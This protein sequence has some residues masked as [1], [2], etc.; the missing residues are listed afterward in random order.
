MSL[1]LRMTLLSGLAVFAAVVL[2][3]SGV[4]FV[5][6]VE[7]YGDVDQKLQDYGDS[8][9]H[10]IAISDVGPSARYL[11]GD[12]T[13]FAIA[14]DAN[15]AEL[16]RSP[17]AT[18][19]DVNVPAKA[20]TSALD[21]QT[22]FIT[23]TEQ[24]VRYRMAVMPVPEVHDESPAAVTS[25]RVLVVGEPLS[26]VDSTLTTLRLVLLG[27]S[28]AAL[29]LAVVL[30]WVV[31]GRSLSPVS[32]LTRAAERLG[33]AGDLSR[34]LPEPETRDEIYRLTAS[35]N[36]S[37]DRLETVYQALAESLT[38]QRRFVADA[39]H[40]LRTPLTVILNNAENLIDHP[41]LTRRDRDEVLEELLGEARRMASLASDLLLLARADAEAPLEAGQLD[42]DRL[43]ADVARDARRLCAPRAVVAEVREPLGPGVADR[44]ALLRGFRILFDNI[45]RHTPEAADVWVDAGTRGDSIWVRVADSGPGVDDHLL[46]HVFDRFFRADPSRHG[47]GT[48]LG[49]AI[50]KSIVE[51]HGGVVTAR[52]RRGGGL[53]VE[54][55]VPRRLIAPAP[56][57]PA[58]QRPARVPP[59][60]R[61]GASRKHCS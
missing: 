28:V 39:S 18:G 32:S 9:A 54:L 52:N 30:G 59:R 51:R 57:E 21:G 8:V 5:S 12:F 7:L 49:L 13:A 34:R 3:S 35:F 46:P 48:G 17:N 24:G 23:L 33:D 38:R 15:G 50:L 43:F 20:R 11:G 45:E 60:E 37:L 1:R 47:H 36:G 58:A 6:S 61:S 40:E 27:G 25:A 29:A 56:P 2:F 31:A 4:Y 19:L 14:Y 26:G 41:E 44:A 42:W 53:E 16:N 10:R 22:D 55:Q